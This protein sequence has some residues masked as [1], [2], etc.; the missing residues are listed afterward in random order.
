MVQRFK[1]GLYTICL[2]KADENGEPYTWTVNTSFVER[3]KK[4]VHFRNSE[5]KYEVN[6]ETRKVNVK[7]FN[8]K[9]WEC[10]LANIVQGWTW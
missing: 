2:V 8:G 1:K 5:A 10:G 6:V 7:P 4:V 3:K 9:E